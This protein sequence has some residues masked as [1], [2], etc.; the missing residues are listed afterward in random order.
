[1]SLELEQILCYRKDTLCR[2]LPNL[3]RWRKKS[4]WQRVDAGGKWLGQE[5]GSQRRWKVAGPE[6]QGARA[7]SEWL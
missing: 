3:A 7:G 2:S 4:R 5:A 6:K 1:M